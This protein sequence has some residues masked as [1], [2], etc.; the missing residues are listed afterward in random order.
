MAGYIKLYRKI[1]HSPIYQHPPLYLRVFE[2]LLIEANHKC[3]RIPYDHGTKLIKRGERLTSIRQIAEW[4]GWYERGIFKVPNP[5]TIKKILDWLENEEMIEILGG[6]IEGNRKETH[7][8]VHGYCI[9][10]AGDTDESNAKVTVGKQSVDTNNNVNK[11]NKVNYKDIFDFY[12]SLDLKKH[13]TY[14]DDMRK[15]IESAMKNNKYDVEYCKTLLERHKKVVEL[16]KNSEYPVRARGLSE[17]FGVKVK[18]AKHLI[19]SEY[20]EGGAKYERYLQNGE[21]GNGVQKKRYK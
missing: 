4:V 10:Q 18:D 9:Y 20:E 8:K 5:K 12:I 1:K 14:T 15:A 17:F 13:R 11:D 3:Q 6:G 2:R 7:Y 19:C 16:T 21:T